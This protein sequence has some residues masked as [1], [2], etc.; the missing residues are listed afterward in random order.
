[1]KRALYLRPENLNLTGL[2]D[3]GMAWL[4]S[5]G[6]EPVDAAPDAF[7]ALLPYDGGGN[8][9]HVDVS[10]RMATVLVANIAEGVEV[11]GI[12]LKDT[13][14]CWAG[15]ADRD[16]DYL[17][18]EAADLAWDDTHHG[19]R[20]T[21]SIMTPAQVEE[22]EQTISRESKLDWHDLGA[23][24]VPPSP[25]PARVPAMPVLRASVS[26]VTYGFTGRR[27]DTVSLSISMEPK[28]RP[29]LPDAVL[30]RFARAAPA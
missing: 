5:E 4:R 30:L 20:P 25:K 2:D 11:R 21:I 24:W 28:L 15:E 29:C 26:K 18:L 1:M 17:E 16:C 13:E 23:V 27:G 14:T 12:H 19:G 3:A 7:V 9:Y 6:F 22:A 8:Y 10:P